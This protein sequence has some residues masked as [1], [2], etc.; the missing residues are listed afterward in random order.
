MSALSTFFFV[1]F[2]MDGEIKECVSIKYCME[3]GKTTVKTLE[4][5]HEA[6]GEHS[7]CLT[8]VFEWHSLFKARQVSVEDDERSVR[9]STSRTTENVEKFENSST[10]SVAEQPMN[11]P[12]PLG[13]VMEFAR[14]T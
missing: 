6:F 4:M 10:K 5:L 12:T 11:S 9:L 3:L 2:A 13:S 1:L 7:L 14:R 8:A